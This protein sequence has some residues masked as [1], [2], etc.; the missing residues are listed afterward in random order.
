MSNIWLTSNGLDIDLDDKTEELVKVSYGGLEGTFVSFEKKGNKLQ[1][2]TSDLDRA[3]GHLDKSCSEATITYNNFSH[4][5][6]WDHYNYK[7]VKGSNYT[8]IVTIEDIHYES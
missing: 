2:Q 7:I 8:V 4:T 3:F 5:I 1:F 6:H